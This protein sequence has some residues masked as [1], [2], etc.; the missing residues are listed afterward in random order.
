MAYRPLA[1]VRV[2]DLA[3]LIPGDLLTRH[4]A[5]LGADVVKVEPP[6]AVDYLRTIPP[7]YEGEGHHHWNLNRGKRSIA[8]DLRN[9][10]EH[11]T[12]MRLAD[13]ADVIVEVS[14]PGR[15]AALGV[16][17][18]AIRRRRPEL[19]VASVTAYGQTGPLAQLPAHGMSMDA[20]AGV[21]FIA[22]REGRA[23]FGRGPVT[24]LANEAAAN[25]G[26]I[27]VIAALYSARMTGQG[28]WIDVSCW[29]AAAEMNRAA[30]TYNLI[31]GRPREIGMDSWSLY[32][33]YEASDG[34]EV[35]LCAIERKFF[36]RFCAGIGRPD[37]MSAWEA[38]EASVDYG[39]ESLRQTLE[40][41]FRMATAEEWLHR[42]IAWDVPGGLI[43]TSDELAEFEV[44]TE[45]GLVERDW[46]GRV[47]NVLGAVRFLDDGSRPGQGAGP[48]SQA[49]ADTAAVV[50][51]WLG[52]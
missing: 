31:E 20:M 11:Q 24:S 15:F 23:F 21:A 44:W 48:A 49:G 6:G 16:D 34:R 28:A 36:E 30:I 3:R 50:E 12:F 17:F 42:L 10:R 18:G 41:V 22:R 25:H 19:V 52:A 40:K 33:I 13:V 29:D 45:R 7:L 37:L 14:H 8:L 39:N 38:G 35:V 51:S 43:V 2:L 46:I 5:D 26:A 27:A 9:E 47:P 32:S 1:G 4:L